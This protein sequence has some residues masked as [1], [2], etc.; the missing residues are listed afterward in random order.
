MTG[1]MHDAMVSTVS[2]LRKIEIVMAM[3]CLHRSSTA[4]ALLMGACL[5]CGDDPLATAPRPGADTPMLVEAWAPRQTSQASCEALRVPRETLQAPTEK[6]RFPSE[7]LRLP[8][9]KSQVPSETLQAPREKLRVP[10]ETVRL[11]SSEP[12]SDQR[13]KGRANKPAR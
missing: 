11:P 4:L 2:W 8:A 1:R 10:R 3:G 9:E 13:R 5:A 7:K 6:L 12:E